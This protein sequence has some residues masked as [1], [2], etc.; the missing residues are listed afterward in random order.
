L[1]DESVSEIFSTN[2]QLNDELNVEGFNYLESFIND[3]I[4][5]Y[6][7]NDIDAVSSYAKLNYIEMDYSCD[8]PVLNTPFY[9]GIQD[10]GAGSKLGWIE[11]KISDDN[12]VHLIRTAIQE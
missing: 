12:T 6:E 1:N 4:S 11:L 9:I 8:N 10:I 2:Y 7:T 3:D 5:I